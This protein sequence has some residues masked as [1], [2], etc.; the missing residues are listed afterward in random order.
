MQ[1]SKIVTDG[2][3]R[4]EALK[5]RNRAMREKL[6]MKEASSRGRASPQDRRWTRSRPTGR[7]R[8]EAATGGSLNSRSSWVPQQQ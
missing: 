5:R 1:I 6:G 3:A 2:S 8:E 4:D 7:L